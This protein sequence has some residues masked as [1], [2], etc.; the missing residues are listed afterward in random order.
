MVRVRVRV[1]FVQYDGN[2]LGPEGKVNA[3]S[4]LGKCEAN[5]R[6]RVRVMNMVVY[7]IW[8]TG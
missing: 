8:D 3:K 2:D 1:W 6:V 5:V 7:S 4:G